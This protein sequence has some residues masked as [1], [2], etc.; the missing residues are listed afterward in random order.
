MLLSS[1]VSNDTVYT[2]SAED[3]C[4]DFGFEDLAHGL[5]KSIIIFHDIGERVTSNFVNMLRTLVSSTGETSLK[6]VR[7]KNKNTARL[8]FSGFI[9]AASNKSPLTKV[10]AEGIQDRRLILIP[11]NRRIEPQAIQNYQTLF[12]LEERQNLVS[13]A[14]QQNKAEIY[15][16]CL[17]AT[18]HPELK[19][20]I[21]NHYAENIDS[22]VMERFISNCIAYSPGDW[23]PYGFRSLIPGTLLDAFKNFICN[24]NEE[25][26]DCAVPIEDAENL[27]K[28]KLLPLMQLL[29]PTWKGIEERRRLFKGKKMKGLTNIC[30]NLFDRSTHIDNSNE[31]HILDYFK[32]C[33]QYSWWV[34]QSDPQTTD[35]S[36]D[37]S[38]D[39]ST[40]VSADVSTDVETDVSTDVCVDVETDPQTTDVETDVPTDVSMDVSMDVRKLPFYHMAVKFKEIL[41][42]YTKNWVTAP[43]PKK[44]VQ[45][46]NKDSKSQDYRYFKEKLIA[47]FNTNTIISLDTEYRPNYNPWRRQLCYIQLGGVSTLD[48]LIISPAYFKHFHSLFLDWLLKDNSIIL[49]FNYLADIPVIMANSTINLE[50]NLFHF[51]IF[52]FY[53]FFRFIAP[54]Y[55]KNSLND[56]S[57]RILGYKLDKSYQ[58]IDWCTV[59]LTNDHI[60]YM[61]NDVTILWKFMCYL[62]TIENNPI[63]CYWKNSW[64]NETHDPILSSLLLDH[65]LIPIYLQMSMKGVALDVEKYKSAL[66]QTK[67]NLG[68]QLANS[69]LSDIGTRSAQKIEKFLQESEI[70]D[71]EICLQLWP[72]TPKSKKLFENFLLRL[73]SRSDVN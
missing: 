61:V 64:L 71:I 58:K 23:Y 35:V 3:F 10:Q 40:D 30:L 50:P 36:V 49:C 37:V 52:D 24:L 32:K 60:T 6:R 55:H 28:Y 38:A 43:N 2:V 53:L 46:I 57:N 22:D 44:V 12:P 54:N 16:F 73:T 69:G 41:L 26:A 51:K 18:Q 27:L 9:C 47:F 56:W 62:N 25:N 72:R 65:T 8:Q 68:E 39:V 5:R 11:F 45:F 15:K 21:L 33:T 20:I 4:C 67:E 17:M 59:Q 7:R 34:K 13:F 63:S 1:L 19:R 29:Y 70:P 14:V 31:N 42:M 48:V 66:S